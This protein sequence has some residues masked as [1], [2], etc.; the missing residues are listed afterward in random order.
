MFK[1]SPIGTILS[2]LEFF[3][4]RGVSLFYSIYLMRYLMQMLETGADFAG[5][6]RLLPCHSADWRLKAGST[7]YTFRK[8]LLR[9][10]NIF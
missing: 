9:F 10:R 8:C 4:W 7:T 6:V 3:I 1:A 5:V 2:F